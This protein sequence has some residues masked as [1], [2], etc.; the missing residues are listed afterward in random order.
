M[1]ALTA[2]ERA[3]GFRAMQDRMTSAQ[4]VRRRLNAGRSP[5]L[6]DS[7]SILDA[8]RRLSIEADRARKE[9][10]QE[11]LDPEDI[12][13]GLLFSI[14]TPSEDG[15]QES[16]GA[17]WLG[18]PGKVGDFIAGLE[19]L[20]G[21]SRLLFLGIVWGVLDREANKGI[22]WARPLVTGPEVEEKLKLAQGLFKSPWRIN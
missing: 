7:L 20:T 19:K 2:D 18:A 5:A 4:R 14:S 16:V 13:L 3:K 15:L 22:M 9:M 6:P 1:A 11:Q 12:H 10:L 8:V 17:K 21:R